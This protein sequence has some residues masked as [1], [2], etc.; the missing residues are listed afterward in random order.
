MDIK[1]SNIYKFSMRSPY[2]VYL[3]YMDNL[4]IYVGQTENLLLRIGVHAK[5]KNFNAFKYFEC[6]S[7]SQALELEAFYI[8]TEN[9]ILNKQ[10]GFL[11][12]S[13]YYSISMMKNIYS[14][15]SV[16]IKRK[17][18]KAGIELISYKNNFFAHKDIAAKVL[19]F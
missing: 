8:I 15:G 6:N 1:E 19:G 10:K 12:E 4:L 11:T 16:E 18:K 7:I 3:L 14:V 9:P 17:F 2:V 5:D 13:K